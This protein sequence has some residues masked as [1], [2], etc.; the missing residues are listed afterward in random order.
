MDEFT[1]LEEVQAALEAESAEWQKA[2]INLQNLQLG[3]IAPMLLDMQAKLQ[4]LINV[5]V[6]DGSITEEGLNFEY[7]KIILNDM[8]A[9]R[10]AAPEQE[11][12]AI[13]QQILHATQIPNG[14]VPK[15]PWMR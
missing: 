5:V 2:G 14:G 6:L 1:T 11:K 9:L 15:P 4:A 8:R 10:E 12:E 7:K 3:A 13:R